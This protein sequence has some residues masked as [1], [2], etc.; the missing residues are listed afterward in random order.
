MFAISK[1][2]FKAQ[3]TVKVLLEVGL[4]LIIYAQIYPTLI[5]P[6]LQTMISTSD[7]TTAALLSIL[8]FIIAL[9]IILGV[10]GF[11]I[12]GGRRI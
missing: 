12:L 3:F 10:V 1:P 7:A 5:E 11:N 9:V 8:P 4:L 6:P 2:F